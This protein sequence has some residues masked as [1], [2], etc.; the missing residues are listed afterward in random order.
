MI[1]NIK[2]NIRIGWESG[3]IKLKDEE[4]KNTYHYTI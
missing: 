4:Q 1:M 2:V 3:A